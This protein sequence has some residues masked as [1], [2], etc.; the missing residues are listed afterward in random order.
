MHSEPIQPTDFP[1]AP[2]TPGERPEVTQG[3]P[4]NEVASST[5]HLPTPVGLFNLG[6]AWLFGLEALLTERERR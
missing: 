4:V 5:P 1:S 6:V 2:P 3:A